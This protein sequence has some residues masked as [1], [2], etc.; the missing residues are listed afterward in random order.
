MESGFAID[1]PRRSKK[2]AEHRPA[3]ACGYGSNGD[4]LYGTDQENG[5]SF[6]QMAGAIWRSVTLEFFLLFLLKQLSQFVSFLFFLRF[7]P[8][9]CFPEVS[10]SGFLVLLALGWR[11]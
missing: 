2:S 4:G 9:F 11:F 3:Y 5:T 10:F 8:R 6:D 1:I 7:L